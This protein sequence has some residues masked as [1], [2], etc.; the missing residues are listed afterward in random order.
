MWRTLIIIVVLCGALAWFFTNQ[1]PERSGTLT[2]KP[3]ATFPEARKA[4]LGRTVARILPHCPGLAQLGGELLFTN[5]TEEPAPEGQSEPL[6]RITF[7]VPQGSRVPAPWGPYNSPCVYDV[8]GDILRMEGGSCQALCLGK[9]PD[10]PTPWLTV[11]L[12]PKAQA[13]AAKQ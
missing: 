2:L 7:V 10:A 11:N 8:A 5:L 4:D 12:N 6:T 13:P 1:A 9:I 3:A